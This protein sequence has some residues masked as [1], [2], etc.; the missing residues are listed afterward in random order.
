MVYRNKLA[1]PFFFLPRILAAQKTMAARS[2]KPLAAE[3]RY[4]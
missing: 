2:L 3:M 4:G 1:S